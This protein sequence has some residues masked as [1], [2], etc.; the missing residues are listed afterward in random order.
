MRVEEVIETVYPE[1]RRI[2][3]AFMSLE[4]RNHTLQPTA[5]VHEAI[6]SIL[7]IPDARFQNTEHFLFLAVGQMRRVLT[8]HARQRL[9]LKRTPSPGLSPSAEFANLEQIL[10]VDQLLDRLAEID[11]RAHSVVLMRFFGGLSTD[12]IA[13]LLKISTGTVHRDWNWARLWLYAQAAGPAS[14]SNS[15]Q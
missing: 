6:L 12:E 1:L 11:L 13:A 8:N 2:A 3:S 4:R 10:I 15:P 5:V 9:T 14:S 7:G